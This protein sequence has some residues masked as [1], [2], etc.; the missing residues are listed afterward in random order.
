MIALD[1]NL[2]ARFLLGDE[3]VQSAAAKR[4]LENPD[5]PLWIPVTV[6]LELAWVLKSR[7]VPREACIEAL[8]TLFAL[9]NVRPQL[10]GAIATAFQSSDGGIDLA[11]ALH[12]ALSANAGKFLSF[13]TQLAKQA[14]RL[15]TYPVVSPP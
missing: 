6:T 5:E 12:L 13:D 4:V 3:P 7:G 14:R 8:R 10:P 11:D 15:G 2:L 1:T 9:P